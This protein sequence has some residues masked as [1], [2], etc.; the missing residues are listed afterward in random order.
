MLLLMLPNR[1]HNLLRHIT[2]RMI[3]YTTYIMTL[4]MVN[5]SQI[6]IINII[7]IAIRIIRKIS[8]IH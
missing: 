8:I 3:A 5:T 1:A 6:I 7:H 2:I 4:H